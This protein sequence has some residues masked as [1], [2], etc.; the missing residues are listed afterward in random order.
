MEG[1]HTFEWKES[2]WWMPGDLK[3][4]ALAYLN[5]ESAIDLNYKY[6]I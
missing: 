1:L 5:A 3:G 6:N 2:L 4:D